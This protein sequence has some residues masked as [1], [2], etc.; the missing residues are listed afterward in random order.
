MLEWQELADAL[1]S[2]GSVRKGVRVRV[3]SLVLTIV[4]GLKWQL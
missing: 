1:L 3:P 2:K 4:G